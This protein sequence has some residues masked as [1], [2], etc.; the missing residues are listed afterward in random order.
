MEKSPSGSDLIHVPWDQTDLVVESLDE[1]VAKVDMKRKVVIG[2]V[3]D[4]ETSL[5]IKDGEGN[6]LKGVPIR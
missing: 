5:V 4:E 1:T 6:I 2:G 3:P